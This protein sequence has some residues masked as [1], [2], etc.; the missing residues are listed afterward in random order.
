MAG[1]IEWRSQSWESARSARGTKSLY[2]D[3]RTANPASALELANGLKFDSEFTV[4]FC[5]YPTAILTE[6]DKIFYLEAT[7]NN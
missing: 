2:F 7:V 3:G 1:K 6:E 4:D 5:F